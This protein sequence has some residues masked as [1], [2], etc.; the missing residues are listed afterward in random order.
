MNIIITG[1]SRGMGKAMAMRFAKDGNTLFLCARTESHLKDVKQEISENHPGATVHVFPAD[2]TQK[3]AVLDFAKFCLTQGVPDILINN[4]GTYAPGNCYDEPE[5][6]LEFMLDINLFSAYYLTRALI[7]EMMKNK[8]GHIFNFCS[9]ASL[10]AY[11]GGGGYGI[12]KF[13]LHGFNLNLRDEMKPHGIK[14][15][16][17]YPGA[18][19]TD[20]W[21]DFDN[22]NKRIMEA[23]DIVEMVYACTKLSP[24][25]VVEEI[26]I[27]P[28]LGDL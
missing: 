17:I 22:S 21:G 1:A 24:Q 9:I 11:K 2:L 19:L 7:P 23:N 10:K 3:Q 5:G 27:R 25:A 16:G 14:V 20:T 18:V 26:I 13:A 28:Q 4:A 12:S 8:C 15:T 6:T